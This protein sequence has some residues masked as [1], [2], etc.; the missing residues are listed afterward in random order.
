MGKTKKKEALSPSLSPFQYQ[1]FDTET[2]E[3]HQTKSP[4]SLLLLSTLLRLTQCSESLQT[5]G[6][7]VSVSKLR[8][9]TY[10]LPQSKLSTGLKLSLVR[11]TRPCRNSFEV[12]PIALIPQS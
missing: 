1:R 2:R 7:T 10:N 11:N 9:V 4:L 3:V 5:A 8:L 6:S 12:D